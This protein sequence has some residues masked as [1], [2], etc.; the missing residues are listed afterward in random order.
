MWALL[1][2]LITK[3]FGV[4]GFITQ[5]V[6]TKAQKDKANA[7]LALQIQ[8]DKLALSSIIAQAAVDSEKN[9]LTATGQGFKFITFSM[10][11]LPIIVTCFA[12]EFGKR[13]FDNLALIPVGWFQLW[14]TVVGVI[15]GLPIA[16]NAMTT[17][18]QSIQQAWDVRNKGKITKIVALGEAGQIG[19]EAAKKEIFDTMKKAVNLNGYT[20]AQVD[21]LSPVLDKVLNI[22]QVTADDK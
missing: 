20:Q 17:I 9:K 3:I 10:I 19:K 1:I 21:I 14:A 16:A 7:E 18:L 2:P 11:S 12:P 8:K 22:A 15:W 4:D 5:L 6:S 13:I